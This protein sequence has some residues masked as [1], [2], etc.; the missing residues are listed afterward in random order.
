MLS[1]WQMRNLQASK[2]VTTSGVS[3]AAYSK[4]I[5]LCEPCF[6]ILTCEPAKIASASCALRLLLRSG[7][8]RLRL[9]SSESIIGYQK[10]KDPNETRELR[11]C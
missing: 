10:I 11:P 2:A 6:Y 5:V 3:S 4:L 9:T 1:R 8:P 7:V